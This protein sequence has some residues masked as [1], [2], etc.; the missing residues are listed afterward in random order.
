MNLNAAHVH[1]MTNHYAIFAAL[2]GIVLL[3]AGMIAKQTGLRLAAYAVLVSAGFA[4]IV[5]YV[6]GS[7]AEEGIGHVAGVLESATDAHEQAGKVTLVLVL[8]SAIAAAYAAWR[9]VRGD[10]RRLVQIAVLVLAAGAFFAGGYTA[11]LGGYIHHPEIR[12]GAHPAR[13]TE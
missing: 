10:A 7:L 12:T 13:G 1:L 5:T 11:L 4:V 9:E 8:L 3:A 2:F 6:S